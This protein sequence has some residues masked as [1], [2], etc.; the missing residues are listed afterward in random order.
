M[1]DYQ[2]YHN[3]SDKN[4]PRNAEDCPKDKGFESETCQGCDSFQT[5]SVNWPHPSGCK[6]M[7]CLEEWAD[8]KNHAD[9]DDRRE[10]YES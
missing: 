8:A 3:P 7:P 6:C 4:D 2:A 5:C 1:A 10:D 9:I